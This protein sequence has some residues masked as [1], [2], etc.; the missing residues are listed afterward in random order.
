MLKNV[1]GVIKWRNV[2][3]REPTR[4]TKEGYILQEFMR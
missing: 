1:L 3:T 4:Q 2:V